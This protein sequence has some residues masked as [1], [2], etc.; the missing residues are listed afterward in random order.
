M[1]GDFKH[2]THTN[3]TGS[4][5][6]FMMF[7]QQSALTLIS[8][9]FEPVL[10]S[11]LSC[12]WTIYSWRAGMVSTFCSH[13]LRTE[14]EFIGPN[15]YCRALQVCEEQE[16]VIS[17]YLARSQSLIFTYVSMSQEPRYVIDIHLL[18]IFPGEFS[19]WLISISLCGSR[20]Q[21][22]KEGEAMR[23]WGD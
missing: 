19:S 22:Q 1:A 10:C 17:S 13:F 8:P 9:I 14:R 11:P 3:R 20:S 23:W 21:N 18:L 15:D 12:S 2:T 5:S 6:F 4:L 16:Q 7:S